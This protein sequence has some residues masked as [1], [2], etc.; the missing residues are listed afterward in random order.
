[1]ARTPETDTVGK[2][3]F[4]GGFVDGTWEGRGTRVEEDTVRNGRLVRYGSTLTGVWVRGKL[5]GRGVRTTHG[6]K[7]AGEF[8]AG[9]FHGEGML[10]GKI[11]DR[12]SSKFT[13]PVAKLRGRF[14]EHTFVEGTITF[15]NGD[16]YKGTFGS[17]GLLRGGHCTGTGTYT[18]ANGDA[19]GMYF[20]A[21]G[22][23]DGYWVE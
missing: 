18:E 9:L 20:D 13:S 4:E 23:F 6:L 2:V 11:P 1:M 5:H 7:Y 14:E 19:V 10:Y 8:K 22:T 3:C 17:D 12:F 15:E 21:D 16:T